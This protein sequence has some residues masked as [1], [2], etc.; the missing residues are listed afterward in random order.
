MSD[1]VEEPVVTPEA[2]VTAPV[3]DPVQTESAPPDL[4]ALL[5]AEFKDEADDPTL[6]EYAKTVNAD[7]IKSLPAEMRVFARALVRADNAR[8]TALETERTTAATEAAA[9]RAAI[10]AERKSVRQQRQ[11]LLDM[12]RKVQPPGPKPTVDPLSQEGMVAHL[13]HLAAVKDAE[14]WAPFRAEADKIAQENAWEAIVEKHAGLR[15][16]K[17]AEAFDNFFV[18]TLNA[19]RDIEKQ[20]SV[21]T[22]ELAADLFFNQKKTA[23][24]EASA[25]KT[26]QTRTAERAAAARAVGRSSGAGGSDL[27]AQAMDLIKNKDFAGAVALAQG[28]PTLRARIIEAAR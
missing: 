27:Y 3:T 2:E 14:R 4:Y 20:G 17:T 24:L 21:I 7:T 12:S 15:D 23:D 11:A 8:K 10:E 19:G 18:N 6:D 5:G 13:E 9:A 16:A 26:A 25:T 1:A 28:N 22:A